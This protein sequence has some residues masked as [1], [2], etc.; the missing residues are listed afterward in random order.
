MVQLSESLSRFHTQTVE[1]EILCILAAFEQPLRL[2]RSLRPDRHQRY[3][4]HVHFARAFGREE[5]RYT[6]LPPFLLPWE[7]NPQQLLTASV[8]TGL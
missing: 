7:S 4:D 6:Q 8:G 2:L 3:P 1:V 5:I